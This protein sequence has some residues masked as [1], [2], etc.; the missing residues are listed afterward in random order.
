MLLL[1][2]TEKRNTEIIKDLAK[3]LPDVV[4]VHGENQAE[5]IYNAIDVKKFR[6]NN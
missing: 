4:R 5:L 2:R 1:N 3:S 6:L